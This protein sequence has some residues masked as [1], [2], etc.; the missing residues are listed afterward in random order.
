MW[1]FIIARIAVL[2]KGKSEIKSIIR[3]A[4]TISDGENLHRDISLAITNWCDERFGKDNWELK[5]CELKKFHFYI[6]E[7]E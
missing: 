2:N 5:T 4:N 7:D 3:E 1:R 6:G